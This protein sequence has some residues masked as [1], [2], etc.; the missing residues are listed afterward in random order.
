VYPEVNIITS[1]HRQNKCTLKAKE[2]KAVIKNVGFIFV[3]S[4]SQGPE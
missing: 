2:S 3:K 4:K 1:L